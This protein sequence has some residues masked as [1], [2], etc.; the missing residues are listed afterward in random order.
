MNL[1]TARIFSIIPIILALLT[2]GCDATKYPNVHPVLGM[3]TL[4][5]TILTTVSLFL[6][7][8]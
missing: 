8:E 5:S 1:K 4:I 2:A 6:L 3:L 7:K